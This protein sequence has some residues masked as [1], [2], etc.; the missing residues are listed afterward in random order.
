MEETAA[1]KIVIGLAAITTI[2]LVFLALRF[3]CKA[4]YG[5]KLGWDDQIALISWVR[6]ARPGHGNFVLDIVPP[7]CAR[8]G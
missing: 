7:T 2:S 4:R 3:Y 5:K 1:P 6:A 8:D